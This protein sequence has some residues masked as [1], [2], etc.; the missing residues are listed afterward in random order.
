[1]ISK[2][3]TC[4]ALEMEWKIKM[5]RYYTTKQW[6][7]MFKASFGSGMKNKNDEVQ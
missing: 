2:S 5:M 7:E 3:N 6:K 1:M 4:W